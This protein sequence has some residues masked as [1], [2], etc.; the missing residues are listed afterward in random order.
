F[1]ANSV[2][3]GGKARSVD[4]PGTNLKE[5]NKFLPGEHG[6]RFF[7]GFYQH[8][9]DTLTRIPFKGKDGKTQPEGVFNNLTPTDT[10]MIARYGKKGIVVN[11]RFPHT[12]SSWK[13]LLDNLF[14][15]ADTGLTEE[16]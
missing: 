5:V 4:V 14:R 10:I 13:V 9:T 2:Y 3:A 1:E 16:E 8:I 7:P 15:G 12:R 6:F 11:A